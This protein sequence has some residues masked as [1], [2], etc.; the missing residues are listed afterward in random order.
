MGSGEPWP[1][2]HRSNIAVQ[3]V[4]PIISDPNYFVL[5][6]SGQSLLF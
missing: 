4:T 3:D 5:D 2:L 1:I 6:S